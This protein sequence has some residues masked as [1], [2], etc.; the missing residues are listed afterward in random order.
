MLEHINSFNEVI[1]HPV[2]VMDSYFV[3]PWENGYSV[4]YKDDAISRYSFP[5][6]VF[7]KS[8]AGL[9]IQNGTKL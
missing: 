3:T 4:K 9:K 2:Q 5:G 7:W 8:D 1:E 6:G